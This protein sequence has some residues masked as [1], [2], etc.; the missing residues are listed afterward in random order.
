MGK[1]KKHKKDK[2]KKR[3]RDDDGAEE[4]NREKALKM[5]LDLIFILCSNGC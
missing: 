3:K 1:E 5:V 2:D 4:R